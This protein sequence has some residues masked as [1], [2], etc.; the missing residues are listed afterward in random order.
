V[1]W[2]WFLVVLMPTIGIVQVGTQSMAD[3]FT[4][5]PHIGLLLAVVW[6]AAE[7]KQARLAAAGL[8]AVILPALAITAWAQTRHWA[9]SVTVAQHAIDVTQKNSV[10]EHNLAHALAEEGR[11]GEAITHFSRA[12]A[13]EPGNYATQYGLGKALLEEGRPGEAEAHFR[14]SA[15]L[16]P[17]YAEA[18]FGLGTALNGRGALDEAAQ[19]FELALGGG[20]ASPFAADAHNNLGVIFA[21]QGRYAEAATHFA[22]A[23]RLKPDLTAAHMNYAQCLMAENRRSEAVAYLVGVLRSN[24][25]NADLRAFLGRIGGL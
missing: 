15:R 7:W 16:K 2:C 6:M 5:F 4:Y 3:R 1:G 24:G 12:I 11:K 19:Q 8:A 23:V 14:E 22:E 10:M 25:E 21:K 13:I 20:L 9:D 17:D 18:H